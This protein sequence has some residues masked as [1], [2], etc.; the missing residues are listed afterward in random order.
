MELYEQIL[1][2]A[3]A[4]PLIIISACFIY[5]FLT[6]D[7]NLLMLAVALLVNDGINGVLK[8]WI[9]KPLVGNKKIFLLGTGRRPDGAK[10]CSP[11]LETNAKPSNSYGMPSGHSQSAVFFSTYVIMNLINSNVIMYE[12]ILGGSIFIFLALGIMYSRVY[13][14]CHTV[15]QV[16]VGGL[17]GL[18][19]GFL[20]YE[21]QEK[22]K[23]LGIMY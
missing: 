18:G 12:K 5:Y 11:F 3:R 4:Y 22:I 21:N 17:I 15:Q 6:N 13:L 1:G 8:Y 14:K 19:L 10:N 2:F 23:N 16:V 20:Y 9:V 7:I